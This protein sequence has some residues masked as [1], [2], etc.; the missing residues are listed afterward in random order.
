MLKLKLRPPAQR[1]VNRVNLA[2]DPELLAKR[3]KRLLDDLEVRSR[4]KISNDLQ[5]D[6]QRSNANES[7][8]TAAASNVEGGLSTAKDRAAARTTISTSTK[9]STMKVR[10]ALL[11]K[12]NLNTIIDESVSLSFN[13]R[14]I[15]L[16]CSRALPI[17]HPMF[18]PI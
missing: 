11:Y 3:R 9:K 14:H 1:Q 8:S 12:K 17:Y 15:C 7:Y 16:I 18:R 4:V 13:C 5:L 2:L 10:T 6:I